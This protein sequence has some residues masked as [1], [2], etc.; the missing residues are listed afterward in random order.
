MPPTIKDLELEESVPLA[1]M[2]T[3]GI[4][5]PARLL[6]RPQSADQLVAA[7]SWA[8]ESDTPWFVLGLGANILVG[9]QG[10]DGLV[11]K[12]ESAGV[13]FEGD[14]LTA[15]SGAIVG[16]LIELCATR[17]LSGIEHFVGIPST[18]G[19]ALWQNLHFLAPDRVETLFIG[20]IVERATLLKDGEVIKVDR[21][22]FN[23]GYDQ[24]TLHDVPAVV[25]DA[26]LRLTPRTRAEIE[27]II[28]ENRQWRGERHPAG[29][30]RISA[31]SIFRKIEGVGAGRLI[32]EA[33]LK[34]TRVGDAEVS[35]HHAN[36]ILN[37]GG[38][39][40]ADVR[41]LIEQVQE[42]VEAS[43]GHRLT[44][45]ISFIGDF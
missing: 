18:L 20:D 4:G 24:S 45:E 36:Y 39:T 9:D 42:A 3:F 38:A 15:E 5:G 37:V 21:E 41:A 22:W 10:F 44:P 23:F 16:E 13:K 8:I 25:L 11:I 14:L 19:G 29:A 2:T 26:T 43:S 17:E 34:G 31:G 1:P 28:A 7:V 27:A 40:A 33:G 35:E 12:N 32:D 30:E 6:A